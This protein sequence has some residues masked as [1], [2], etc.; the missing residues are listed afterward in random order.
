MGP[1]LQNRNPM[2]KL[3]PYQEIDVRGMVRRK[4]V[5]NANEMGLGKTVEALEVIYRTKATSALIIAPKMALG[6]FQAELL[7]WYG[8]ESTL[9]DGT[10]KQ[11]AKIREAWKKNPTILI[12]N[13]HKIEELHGMQSTWDIIIC[14]EIHAPNVGL[15]NHKNKFYKLFSKMRSE[16]LILMTG[17]PIRRSIGDLFAPLHLLDRRKFRGFYQFINTYG[18]VTK[19][20]YGIEIANKPKNPEQF[21]EMLRYYMIRRRKKEVL[22]DLPP[23]QRQ[24]LKVEMSKVQKRAYKEIVEEDM[25]ETDDDILL[26]GYRMTKDLRLR[27]LLVSPKILGID[28]TGGAIEALMYQLDKEFASK[29]SVLICTPFRKGIE[30]LR[31]E[32]SKKFDR[33]DIFEIHGGIKG[34]P[35]KVAA[36]FQACQNYR[37]VMLLVI[38]SGAS[39]TITDASSAYFV[40]YEWSA[41][42]NYQAEDRIHRIGQKNKV[43]IYYLLHENTVDDLVLDKLREKNE[44]QLWILSP[45]AI[46]SYIAQHK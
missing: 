36:E 17:T 7:K 10:P 14:D 21:K 31:E 30:V 32:I 22:K 5:Y 11:R 19:G 6:T 1:L 33:V 35:Q 13:I 38:K 28:D 8:A 23:K 9:Y 39:F 40:G 4:K 12:S 43:N 16:Y 15:L 25:L 45:A 3:R 37:K 42:E 34:L 29:R 27:Q 24:S 46:R 26:M 20:M 44:S 18:I 2:L 41:I